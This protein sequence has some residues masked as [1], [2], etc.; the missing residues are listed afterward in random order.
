MEGLKIRL[1]TAFGP[2]VPGARKL[3]A[4]AA[5]LLSATA[6]AL[7]TGVSPAS[8]LH[9]MYWTE[10]FDGWL[11]PGDGRST[12][13]VSCDVRNGVEAEWTATG[14]RVWVALIDTSG[15][16]FRSGTSTSG[17]VRV[18]ENPEIVPVV[19]AHC[20]NGESIY[21]FAMQCA[22]WTSVHHGLCA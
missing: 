5:A 6:C 22:S 2:G 7:A 20:K 12:G 9:Q 19:R 16:W 3:T 17:F 11:A 13:Y 15:D 1:R 18:L 14:W 21:S 4:Y 10:Y 8:A